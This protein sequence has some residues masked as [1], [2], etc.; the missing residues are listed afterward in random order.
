MYIWSHTIIKLFE[1]PSCLIK[2]KQR[3]WVKLISPQTVEKVVCTLNIDQSVQIQ[4]Y[5]AEIDKDTSELY[6]GNE[7]HKYDL[8]D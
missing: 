4:P 5:Y 8:A 1:C 6:N 7:D 2:P 3:E